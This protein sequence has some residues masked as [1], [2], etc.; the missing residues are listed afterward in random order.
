MLK[1]ELNTFLH[2][3]GWK[4]KYYMSTLG[5]FFSYFVPLIIKYAT[6]V[7]HKYCKFRNNLDDVRKNWDIL[8]DIPKRCIGTSSMW[9]YSVLCI[10]DIQYVCFQRLLIYDG[11]CR[12]IDINAHI[13]FL[14]TNLHIVINIIYGNLPTC[15]YSGG[16]FDIRYTAWSIWDVRK[17]NRCI[18][19]VNVCISEQFVWI[20]AG[21]T[22]M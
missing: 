13:H 8:Y 1:H 15:L 20:W 17:V 3:D 6:C 22:F 16:Q 18:Q 9:G 2:N 21:R 7:L 4:Q 11:L 14:N 19:E 5:S 12:M 10:S